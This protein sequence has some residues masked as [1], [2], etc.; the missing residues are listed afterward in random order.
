MVTPLFRGTP[1]TCAVT[2]RAFLSELC[3]RICKRRALSCRT[4]GS[5][6]SM[7][8]WTGGESGRRRSGVSDAVRR[9]GLLLVS[10][11]RGVV[12]RLGGPTGEEL[13]R[14]VRRA[15]GLGAVHDQELARV[16]RQ[17]RGLEGQLEVANE[18]VVDA[19]AAGQ[20]SLDVVRGPPHAEVVA[21]RREQTDQVGQVAVVGVAAS[22]CS[23]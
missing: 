6:S 7:Y 1:G 10:R 2:G 4:T 14:R 13:Q 15:V 12:A 5:S 19:L 16:G 3:E 9:G 20:V 8:A 21:A 18:R 22:G 23:Q 17:R 11:L